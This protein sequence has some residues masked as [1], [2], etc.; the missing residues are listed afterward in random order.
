MALNDVKLNRV[1]LIFL[2]AGGVIFLLFVFDVTGTRILF[3][4]DSSA[5]SFLLSTLPQSLAALFAITFSVLIIAIEFSASK[6]TPKV[7]HFLLASIFKDFQIAGI[8]LFFI[9]A[10]FTNFITLAHV[11]GVAISDAIRVF[12]SLSVALTACCFLLILNLFRRIPRFFNPEDIINNVKTAALSENGP[13]ENAELVKI[14]GDI[15]RKETLQGNV[16]VASDA[17]TALEDVSVHNFKIRREGLNEEVLEQLFDIARTA[18]RI[19]DTI[20]EIEVVDSLRALCVATIE[21]DSK[22][23]GGFRYLR[24]VGILALDRSRG[25]VHSQLLLSVSHL[26]ADLVSYAKERERD[27]QALFSIMQFF[28]LGSFYNANHE[29]A[30]NHIIEDI[31]SVCTQREVEVAFNG[32]MEKKETVRSYFGGKDPDDAMRDFYDALMA[33]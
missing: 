15:I 29:S 28:I 8:I 11:S 24:E 26:Y 25:I 32:L 1:D 10:M 3:N 4:G 14:L 18:I 21:E 16:D 6:Y 12:T 30:A 27:A 7:L 20:T 22:Y 23:L 33:Y 5:A 9:A 13:R 31:T 2:A 17:L 19:D